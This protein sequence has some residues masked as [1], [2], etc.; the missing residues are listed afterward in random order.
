MNSISFGDDG[1]KTFVKLEGSVGFKGIDFKGM[2]SNKVENLTIEA[3]VLDPNNPQDEASIWVT[4]FELET[5]L[6]DSG[7]LE[8]FDKM[9]VRKI[10][11]QN[12]CVKDGEAI[13]LESSRVLLAG[14]ISS[15]SDDQIEGLPTP[16]K[17]EPMGISVSL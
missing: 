14:A 3:P 13:I 17:D 12:V 8:V 4:D 11:V 7:D 10:E 9:V 15:G 6:E 5:W 1:A 16:M 2:I